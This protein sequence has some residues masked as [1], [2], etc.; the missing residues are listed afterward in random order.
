MAKVAILAIH[1]MGPK[2]QS[3]FDEFEEKLKQKLKRMKITTDDYSYR[4]FK[5]FEVFR[6]R[7]NRVFELTEDLNW[8]FIRYFLTHYLGDALAYQREAGGATRINYYD[9][10]HEKLE[11]EVTAWRAEI[12]EDV[13]LVLVAHSLGAYIISNYVWDHQKY[14]TLNTPFENMETVCS[15]ITM[16]CNIPI[17]TLAF[18]SDK[19]YPINI[20]GQVLEDREVFD[21]QNYYT[22]SDPLSMPLKTFYNHKTDDQERTIHKIDDRQVKIGSLLSRWTPFSHAGYWKDKKMTDAVA[23]KIKQIIGS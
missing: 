2:D 18:E 16:G 23:N 17:L 15:F 1:G 11:K 14:D 20:P 21:W 10:I 3:T 19:L 22:T 12:G 6:E 4:T 5:Y 8:Q 9:L 13:P 7:A